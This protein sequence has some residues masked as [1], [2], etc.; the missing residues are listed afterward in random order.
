MADVR[1]AS[2]VATS[3]P[4][5]SNIIWLN[6]VGHVSQ[7][8]YGWKLP[9]GADTATCLL[10]RPPSFRTR[11]M[12][13]GRILRIF[14]GSDYIWQ[15]Q[16][17]EP[18]P[19][20]S[21]WQISALGL[22]NLGDRFRSLWTVSF[23][24]NTVVNNAIA[25]GLP[26]VNPGISSSGL[27][28]SQ[29]Q[30]TAS[31]SVTSFMNL[32]TSN[33]GMTWYVGRFNLLSVTALPSVTAGTDRLLITNEPVARSIVED[34]NALY[35]RYQASSDNTTSGTPATYNTV[36]STLSDGIAAHGRQEDFMDL[37]GAGT[38][39]GTTATAAA[40]AVL[41]KYQRAAW[42]GPFTISYGQVT[43]PGGRPCD[44][45]FEQPGLIYKLMIS[46]YGYGGEVLPGP[47]Q[48]L[49]GATMFDDDAHQLT[50]TPFQYVTSSLQ[51][52][53]SGITAALTPAST[54]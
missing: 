34:V 15:G 43:T 30:D 22:G 38:I 2:Y 40:N 29:S 3:K 8:K 6:E 33:G 16:I 32:I 26:W 53:I 14:R 35:V 19:G 21:G 39:S 36:V 7:L 46:D 17:Q 5:G 1:G 48:F 12:D 31:Q 28:L 52:M 37:S 50:V 13:P 24:A 23:N 10:S 42:V 4:D 25:N 18:A 49:A 44:L 51:D 54:Q 11:A 20:T 9:G 41:S 27:W 45:G 47:I